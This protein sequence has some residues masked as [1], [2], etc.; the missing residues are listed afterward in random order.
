[1]EHRLPVTPIPITH[2]AALLQFAEDDGGTAGVSGQ[3]RRAIAEYI[4]RRTRRAATVSESGETR[5]LVL[6]ATRKRARARRGA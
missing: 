3:V 1:M 6:R 5:R 4:E 2:H